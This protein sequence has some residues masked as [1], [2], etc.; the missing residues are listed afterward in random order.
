ME[1]E[2]TGSDVRGVL[3]LPDVDA[4]SSPDIAVY[5]GWRLLAPPV[6]N[7]Y[8]PGEWEWW[9]ERKEPEAT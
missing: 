4:Y 6:R 1:A 3:N 9:F 7:L 2:V 5:H 8:N